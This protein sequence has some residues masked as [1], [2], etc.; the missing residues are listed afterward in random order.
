[1]PKRIIDEEKY[2]LAESRQL[3]ATFKEKMIAEMGQAKKE[4]FLGA[5]K[6][7]KDA[8]K[9]KVEALIMEGQEKLT[10][11]LEQC[12]KDHLALVEKYGVDVPADVLDQ[13]HNGW[14]KRVDDAVKAIASLSVI[15]DDND[16][17][18]K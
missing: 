6:S 13:Y 9:Q 2:F 12:Q 11:F 7:L 17:Q 16:Y 5:F 8:E 1:M 14:L 4:E 18:G 3:C 15:L 10:A